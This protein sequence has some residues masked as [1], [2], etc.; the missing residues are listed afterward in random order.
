[1]FQVEIKLDRSSNKLGTKGSGLHLA[2]IFQLPSFFVLEGGAAYPS[3]NQT[4]PEDWPNK[5][6]PLLRS[7]A[8]LRAGLTS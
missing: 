5:G 2:G 6:E 1:M 8:F 7:P 3:E 4:S